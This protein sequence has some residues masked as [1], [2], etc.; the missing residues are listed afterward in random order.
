MSG[1]EPVSGGG[2]GGH[3]PLEPTADEMK[4]M[5][6]Q[7][8]ERIARFVETLPA[9]PA[10]DLEGAEALARALSAP[11]PEHGAPLGPILDLLF[12][13]AVPKAFNTTGPGYLAYIPG[14]GLFEAGLAD[15]IADAVNRFT[16]IWM[17]APLLVQLEADVLRWLCGIVG[18]GPG[19]SGFLTTGGSLANL[20]ALITARHEKLGESFS[21]G[22]MYVS[23]QAHH[24]VRKAA[25]LAGFPAG[26]VRI[27]PTDER[28]RLRPDALLALLKEDRS[29][30]LR[31]FLIVA[32]AGTTNTGAVDPLPDLADMAAREGLWLHVDGAYGGFFVL[33]ERG[34]RALAGIERADSIV[35]DPHKGMFLPYG[36][37]CLLAKDG[38]TL[39]RAHSVPADYLPTMQHDADRVDFSEISPEL[40]RDYRGLRVWLPLQLRGTH[41]FQ[42]ALDEKLDLA[43]WAHDVLR[44][45]D[46]IEIVAAPQLSLVVFRLRRAELEGEALD[47]L[48][49]DFLARVNA[50]K[51][52][53]LSATT[54]D[55]MFVLRICV[56]SFRTHQDRMEMALEDIRA[57][58]AELR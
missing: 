23:D 38:E 30:G 1:K 17:P 53:Y 28:F 20:S 15:L 35:L 52:V 48:N 44:T 31:P 21:D 45:I 36:T 37:G 58:V 4:T 46:G 11:M 41:A 40:S 50:R 42:E 43:A 16:G 8:M 27:V 55:G 49:R 5:A 14:G 54:A 12:D 13:R 3:H 26:S 24:S 9:Q 56:L 32:S 6:G 34:R 51:R 57:A 10:S 7:A 47:T 22:A 39:R 29:A 33:T 25:R 19:S 18:Y 2:G